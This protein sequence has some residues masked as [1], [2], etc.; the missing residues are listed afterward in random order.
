[1]FETLEPAQPDK[2]LAL[3][4]LVRADPRPKKVDLGVGVYKDAAGNTPV[5]AAVREA[6]KRLCAKQTTKAYIGIA[7]DVGFNAA[8]MR[9]V[10]GEQADLSRIRA[11]QAPGASG[12]LKFIA[13]LMKRARPI[14][15]SGFRIRPG[16]IICRL[17]DRRGS[18]PRNTLTSMLRPVRFASMP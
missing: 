17:S 15:R 10:F 6:E 9:L 4:G 1:M 7:G 14:P 12:A 2:I 16:Q 3:I 11:L 13:E 8:M 5:M 18:R